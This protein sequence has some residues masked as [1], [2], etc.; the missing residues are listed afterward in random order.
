[1]INS[2]FIPCTILVLLFSSF[3]GNKA[4][5]KSSNPLFT[6]E[7]A[8]IG[9]KFGDK[10][11]E[12]LAREIL[13][14]NRS[15]EVSWLPLYSLAYA[16]WHD[17]EHL[18][19][20]QKIER[21]LNKATASGERI[22]GLLSLYQATGQSDYLERAL[23]LAKEEPSNGKAYLSLYI[24]T[25]EREWLSLAVA[26]TA[27]LPR[28]SIESAR[29]LNLLSHYVGKR[30][31][32]ILAESMVKRLSPPTDRDLQI[33]FRLVESELKSEPIHIAI[34]GKK[35]DPQAKALFQAALSYPSTYKRLEWWDSREGPLPNP[36][37]TYP[38][39][40]QPAAFACANRSCSLPVFDPTKIVGAVDRLRRRPT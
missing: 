27:S 19:R 30:D 38:V 12:N 39:L 16:L 37:V 1:M 5:P 34:V 8:L 7:F 21:H 32:R 24:S 14:S 15:F 35:G 25:A 20:A 9:S 23:L 40:D 11:Q 3:A 10:K 26:T 6:L 2:R 31:L 28:N 17:P 36:D 33:G 4:G 13:G 18:D 22:A 29:F